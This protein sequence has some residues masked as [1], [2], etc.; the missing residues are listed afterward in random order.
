MQLNDLEKVKIEA[1]CADK[2]MYNAVKKV[3]LAGIYSHGVI[4]AGYEHNPLENGAFS[5]AS[6]ATEN[7]I[8][9]EVLGQHIRGMWAGINALHN[10]F[11]RLDSVQSKKP[12]RIVTHVNIAE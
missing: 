6:V 2:D 8:P 7:P 1:F 4:E 12:K 9:D 11:N 3:I 5:L 10:A